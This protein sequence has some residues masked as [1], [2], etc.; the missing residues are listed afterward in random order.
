[1]FHVPV[2]SVERSEACAAKALA[3]FNSYSICFSA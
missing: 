2:L 1:M 3:G